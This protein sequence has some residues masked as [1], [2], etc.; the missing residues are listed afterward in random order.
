M[1]TL[2]FLCMSIRMLSILINCIDSYSC[3][4]RFNTTFIRSKKYIIY[5]A[6]F[7]AELPLKLIG[8][9]I[10]AASAKLH[11][12]FLIN[13]KLKI[14]SHYCVRYVCELSYWLHL[15]RPW[16]CACRVIWNVAIKNLNGIHLCKGRMNEWTK[17]DAIERID[18]GN[19]CGIKC[20]NICFE[21]FC[22]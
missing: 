12:F 13:T 5:C 18:I 21:P 10:R 11:F 17:G 15:K 3:S 19:A 20:N 4:H 2:F 22:G 1:T 7:C 9:K 14:E 16:N 8:N 6:V